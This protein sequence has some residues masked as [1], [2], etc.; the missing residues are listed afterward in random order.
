MKLFFIIAFSLFTVPLLSQDSSLLKLPDSSSVIVHKDPR[1]DLLVKKQ[2]EI[3]EAIYRETRRTAKGFRIMVINTSKRN[4]AIDAKAKM[5]MYFPELK[6]YL[7]YQSPYFR[8]KVGN[9]RDRDDAE[10]YQKK[11]NKYF[12]NG[13]F[14]VNDIIEVK[15]GDGPDDPAPDL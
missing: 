5:Y 15:P 4:E 2:S 12:P 3:N 13:V 14:V 7:I 11:I 9:F 6:A 1:L 10:E 8:L